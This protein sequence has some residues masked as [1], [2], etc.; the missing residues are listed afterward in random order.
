[1]NP[2]PMVLA[3]LR[4]MGWT[5]L[6]VPLLVAFAVASAV[7][8]NAQERM[9]RAGTARAAADFP[10]LIGAAGS[11]A[12]LVMTGVYLDLTALNLVDGRVLQALAADPRVAA[13]AP[14]AFGDVVAGFP[15]VGTTAAFAGR[16]GRLA[17]AEGR[18]FA[19]AGEAVVGA[20]VGFALGARLTP[21]HGAGHPHDHSSDDEAEEAA[22]RHAGVAYEVVG[23]MPRV[24]SPWDRA[25]LVPVETV[26]ATH[27]L[28]SGHEREGLGAPYDGERVPGVPAIVVKPRRVSDAYAL[29]QAYR[30]DG[31]VA[32][33]PAEILVSL[34]R[35]MGDVRDVLI[36][37]SWFNTGLIF[38]ALALLVALVAGLRRRRYAV[39]RALGAPPAYILAVVWL[40]AAAMLGVG[41][42]L[43]LALGW[44]GAVALSLAIG[45]WTGLALTFQPAW[46]DVGLAAGL[47]ALGCLVAAVP[48]L[49]AYRRPIVAGLRG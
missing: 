17:P 46:G 12:Q 19:R 40:G 31:T 37:A 6:A 10:L 33:F 43:G 27:G 7:A 21:A 20:E 9:L 32:V 49:L 48:A 22:R 42:L 34:Y 24:G 1:M 28:G 25:I 16:W 41:A 36:A 29:R 2:L 44:L 38:A 13:S 4:A 3:D 45:T 30:R 47:A 14:I 8:I 39:L 5:G 26:W 18:L 23:R 15:V 11:E 35:R